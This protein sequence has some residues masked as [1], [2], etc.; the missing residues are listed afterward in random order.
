PVKVAVT[1]PNAPAL[2]EELWGAMNEENKVSLFV[3]YIDL[4][5]GFTDTVIVNKHTGTIHAERKEPLW[6]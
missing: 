6:H 3:Q 4:R 5:N 2:A 1:A